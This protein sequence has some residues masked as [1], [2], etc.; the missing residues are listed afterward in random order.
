MNRPTKSKKLFAPLLITLLAASAPL[1]QTA[2]RGGIDLANLD[3]SANPCDDFYQFA[4]GGWLAKNPIPAAY[5]AWGVGNVLDEQNQE[6]LHQIVEAAAKNTSAPKGSNERKIGDY[7]AACMDEAGIEAA[8][9][10]PLETEFALI[11]K[12]KTVRALQAEIALL[13]DIGINVPFSSG[14]TQDFK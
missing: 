10:K 14:S 11:D 6:A 13:A 2:S 5:P 4:N 1:A 9:L 7:Y 12:I 3:K 8:G